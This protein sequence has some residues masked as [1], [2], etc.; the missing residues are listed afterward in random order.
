MKAITLEKFNDTLDADLAWRK[1]EIEFLK[2]RAAYC[3]P[4][5]QESY[6][7]SGIALAYAHWEGFIK[8]SSN[9]YLEYVFSQKK[10]FNEL[11]DNFFGIRIC[12][13]LLKDAKSEKQYLYTTFS[14][15]YLYTYSQPTDFIP[16]NF[17]DSKT[18]HS[19]LTPELFTE[20]L[21]I[22]GIKEKLFSMKYS[23]INEKIL[24]NRNEIAHGERTIDITYD[25]LQ[26]VSLTVIEMLDQYKDT[27]LDYAINKKYLK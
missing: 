1:K 18:I 16:K 17:I 26:A 25:D 15:N 11:T 10:K 12:N 22:I 9:Q 3:K 6:I 24:K 13:E 23:F 21:Q 2:N 4:I 8:K 20:I 5:A 7:R 14:E 19:N 27:L